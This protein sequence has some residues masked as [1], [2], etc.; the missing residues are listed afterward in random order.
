M[1]HGTMSGDELDHDELHATSL[2][3][4]LQSMTTE[5]FAQQFVDEGFTTLAV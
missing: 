5:Q 4:W 2:S 3:I 1:R